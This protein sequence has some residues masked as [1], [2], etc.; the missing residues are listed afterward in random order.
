VATGLCVV[1]KQLVVVLVVAVVAEVSGCWCARIRQSIDRTTEAVV[2]AVAYIRLAHLER[3]N[4]NMS[5]HRQHRQLLELHQPQHQPLL[6][7]LLLLLSPPPHLLR[8]LHHNQAKSLPRHAQHLHA[9]PS[10]ANLRA[11]TIR[12]KNKTKNKTKNKPKTSIK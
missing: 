12:I 9:N 4:H 11:K 1:D 10:K 5:Q 2:E 3:D 6:L 7:L 8:R